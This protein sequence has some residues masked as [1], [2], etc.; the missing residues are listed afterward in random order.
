MKGYDDREL[1][2]ERIE[3]K[4]NTHDRVMMM[5]QWLEKFHL[6][7]REKNQRECKDQVPQ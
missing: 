4:V 6:L 5:M 2:N 1:S 3:Q 7:R